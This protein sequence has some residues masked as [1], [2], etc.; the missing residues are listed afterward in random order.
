MI[1]S[2]QDSFILVCVIVVMLCVATVMSILNM[3]STEEKEDVK[4]VYVTPN[5]AKDICRQMSR[6]AVGRDKTLGSRLRSERQ[7]PARAA[8]VARATSPVING[9]MQ[10]AE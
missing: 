6:S 4:R 7:S 3:S 10:A 8:I 1:I 5:R 9:I 2:S